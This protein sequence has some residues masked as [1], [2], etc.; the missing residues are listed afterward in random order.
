MIMDKKEMA[1]RG[2]RN[3][4]DQQNVP[5][6][7]FKKL[8]VNNVIIGASNWDMNL[9]FGEIIGLDEKGVPVVE[10]KVKL[11]MSKEFLKAVANL[12]AVNVAVYEERFGEIKF[13]DIENMP[14]VTANVTPPAKAKPTK[15][16]A[17][18]RRRRS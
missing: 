17:N 9:T 10:Q 8:Y 12:L 14:E 16:S 18:G 6:P 4:T 3:A 5:S 13:I 2:L 15:A 1:K 11:N 7:E